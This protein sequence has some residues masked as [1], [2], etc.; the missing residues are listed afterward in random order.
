MLF[1]EAFWVAVQTRRVVEY[2]RYESAYELTS[3]IIA[4]R[5]FTLPRWDD[6]PDV[7][8]VA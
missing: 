7:S 5:R 1:G 4:V 6:Y 2:V 8:W 3:S